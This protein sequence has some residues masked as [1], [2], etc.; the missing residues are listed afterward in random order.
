MDTIEGIASFVLQTIL[1]EL[2]IVIL[3]VIFARL[4]LSRWEKWRYGKW[5]VIVQRQGE[6]LVDRKISPRKAKEILEEPADLSVF[7][8]GTVS[9]YAFL[10]CDIIQKGV[11]RGLFIKDEERRLLVV[12]L[13]KNPSGDNHGRAPI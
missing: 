1:G 12:D 2:L 13:D 7:L 5:R 6:T 3:G 9:P 4:V 11:E 10:R 8:K